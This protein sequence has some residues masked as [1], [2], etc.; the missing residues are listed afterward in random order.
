MIYF[1]SFTTSIGEIALFAEDDAIIRLI[2]GKDEL[3]VLDKM[4]DIYPDPIEAGLIQM[5]SLPLLKRAKQQLDEYLAGSRTNFTVPVRLDGAPFQQQ[6]WQKLQ[7]I[8]YGETISYSDLAKQAG[9]EKAIRAAGTGCGA[10]PIPLIVPCHRVT[11]KDG[12]LGGFALGLNVKEQLL[13][14]EAKA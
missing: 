3:D 1:S 11:Q 8:P 14:L 4:M 13:A 7:Q 10:N 2:H 12:G 5:D 6:V 9:N